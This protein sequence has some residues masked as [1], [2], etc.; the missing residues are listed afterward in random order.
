MKRN[1]QDAESG[2][3]DARPPAV[4]NG[5]SF[6]FPLVWGPWV[7]DD[8]PPD[9]A[10]WGMGRSMMLVLD[11]GLFQQPGVGDFVDLAEFGE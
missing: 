4:T 5:N 10:G 7:P 9:R 6:E 1:A 2:E 11:A 8:R 3:E